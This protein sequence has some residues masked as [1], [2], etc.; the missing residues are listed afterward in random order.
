MNIIP[1]EC[2]MTGT[3][4]T[5]DTAMQRDIWMRMKRTVEMIA[6]SAGASAEISFEKACP[7]V[8]NPPGLVNAMLPSL[9]AAAGKN[10]VKERR[11]MTGAE[12]FSYY[13]LKAPAFFF[14]LGG[15][16][17]GADPQKAPGHHT[18]T[19]YID[20]SGFDVGVKAFCQLV[21]DYGRLKNN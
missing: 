13:G 1:D 15:M 6:E 21:F 17:K 4:R 10:N 20:E 14:N 18:T 7:V 19:F 8:Y 5:L 3:I 12:D 2:V 16:P 11:W 9:R